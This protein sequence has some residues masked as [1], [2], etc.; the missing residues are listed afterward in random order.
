MRQPD[1]SERKLA[2]VVFEDAEADARER[3][4]EAQERGFQKASDEPQSP[5]L[6]P[7]PESG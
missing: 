1:Q 6:E 2:T 3:F 4:H 7:N 5:R